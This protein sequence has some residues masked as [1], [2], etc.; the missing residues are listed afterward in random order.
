MGKITIVTTSGINNKPSLGVG[1]GG[2]RHLRIFAFFFAVRPIWIWSDKSKAT[3][4]EIWHIHSLNTFCFL[5]K[6]AKMKDFIS[7]I[8]V[9]H[10]L[11]H[12]LT[13]IV[14]FSPSSQDIKAFYSSLTCFKSLDELFPPATAVFMVG[15]PYY[16]A[17]GEVRDRFPAP[18]RGS[19]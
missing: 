19:V 16:G 2:C 6:R 7:Q 10:R 17:M 14:C 11:C 12:S 4:L 5:Q 9:F 1:K 18:V 15:N 13:C 3:E 8:D